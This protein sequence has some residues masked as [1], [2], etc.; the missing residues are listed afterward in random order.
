[1]SVLKSFAKLNLC[2]H[3]TGRR[4]D[5]YHFLESIVA[6][7]SLHDELTVSKSTDY[8][9]NIHVSGQFA[10][11]LDI[12]NAHQLV[13]Q[14]MDWYRL[15][16]NMHCPYLSVSLKKNIP[17][18]AGL[19]GGSSN[20]ATIM[21]YLFKQYPPPESN[22]FRILERI[23]ADLGADVPLFFYDQP[24]LVRGIGEKVEP[25]EILSAPNYILLAYPH[26]SLSTKI[27]Y[28]SYHYAGKD[29]SKPLSVHRS[30]S[31]GQLEA[32]HNDLTDA[33]MKQSSVLNTVLA[34][35]RR[36]KGAQLVRMTGS[37][38]CCFAFFYTKEQLDEAYD[39]MQRSSQSLWLFKTCL[40]R[41]SA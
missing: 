31:W 37:G 8:K 36:C 11:F 7:I 28:E 12:P 39:M 18:G 25:L 38:S 24:V 33:A 4:H 14:S 26:E 22:R 40:K 27:V 29:F 19:G 41:K 15:N 20:A 1:M 2:L 21:R 3:I 10:S 35:L 16:V 30:F 6:P 17:V 32:F 23:A 34:L 13:L 5:G 9:N